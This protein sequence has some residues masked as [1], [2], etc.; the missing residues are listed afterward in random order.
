[1][2]KIEHTLFALPFT[3]SAAALAI[4]YQLEQGLTF[5]P[6]VFLWIALCLLGARSAGMTL[7]RIIDSD[8]DAANPRTA[9]REIPSG[10]ISKSQAWLFTIAS[11]GVLIFSAFQLPKLCQYLLP[12]PIIWVWV[13]PY[14]KRFTWFCHFFLGTTLGGATLGGWIAITGSVDTLAPIYLALAV[15]S[16][17]SGFDIIYACQDYEH[18]IQAGIRSIPAKFGLKGAL[19]ISK[20]LHFM[21]LLMMYFAG[22]ALI[23]GLFYKLGIAATMVALWYEHKLANEALAET[24]LA[25]ID[26]AFFTVNSWISVVIFVFVLLEITG[27]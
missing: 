20:F 10:K 9:K 19:Q 11:L 17:V 2:I 1:M 25:K 4:N 5:K 15:T 14:L 23:L 26:K 8:I 13:Y 16:W 7:N 27:H 6:M 3:L 24:N 21:M 22:E 18:D 12:I